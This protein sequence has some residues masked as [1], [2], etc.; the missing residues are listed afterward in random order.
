MRRDFG[1]AGL[2]QRTRPL[3]VPD[4]QLVARLEPERAV[5]LVQIG[6]DGSRGEIQFAG[7][8][9]VGF[10]LAGAMDDLHFERRKLHDPDM[11]FAAPGPYLRELHIWRILMELLALVGLW[12]YLIV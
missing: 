1:R 7:D 2:R 12:P 8:L 6:G 11:V 10:A 3:Q 4:D 5:D 9:P